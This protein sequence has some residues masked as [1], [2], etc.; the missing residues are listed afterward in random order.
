MIA[1]AD[2]RSFLDTYARRDPQRPAVIMTGSG[3]TLTYAELDQR[4]NQVAHAL[5]T[6][7]LTR[8]ARVAYLLDNDTVTFE[9][10][11]GA[12]RAGC[13]YTP[14]NTRLTADEAAYIVR[15]CGARA[16][17]VSARLASLG[18]AVARLVPEVELRVAVAGEIDGFARY[19]DLLAA[20]PATP[21]DDESQGTAMMYSSGTTGWPK[22]IERPLPTRPIGAPDSWLAGLSGLYGWSEQTRYLCPAPLYHGAG[23]WYTTAMHRIGATALVME[24]FDAEQMLAA[25]EKYHVNCVQVVPTMF[26]RALK[27]PEEVRRRYDLSSLR[28]VLH[29]AAPCPVPVKEAM[30]EWLGPIVFEYYAGTEANGYCWISPQE[31]LEH[32]GSVGKAVVGVPHIVGESGEELPSG[33]PGLIYFETPGRPFVYHHDTKKTQESRHPRGWTTVGDMG[34][35]DEDGYLYLTDRKAH[36]IIS[37][38]VNIYPQEAENF[39]TTHPAVDDVAVIGVPNEEFGEEVKAVVVP[40]PDHVPGPELAAELIDAC[41]ASLAHYKCPKTVDFVDELPRAENGKLYKR[42]L[43][44]RYWQGRASRLI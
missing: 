38:G 29:A 39:L 27:L 18:E 44:D 4:S 14:I 43:R 5:R 22:G 32:K 3:K 11:W 20:H 10:L 34:Y 15:D 25:I 23:L 35:L 2:E 17:I 13:Y 1:V 36:M 6:A 16:L 40:A 42:Q 30:L 31:W 8:G 28:S 41:R 7:G 26:V 19:E 12:F 37:G 33:E 24:K 9:V 21:L